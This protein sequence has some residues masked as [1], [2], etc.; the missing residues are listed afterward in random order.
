MLL[1]P[2]TVPLTKIV[3][4]FEP[5]TT[6][7]FTYVPLFER[8]TLPSIQIVPLMESCWV[9]LFQAR[10]PTGL[11]PLSL[12]VQLKLAPLGMRLTVG[13]LPFAMP[14]LS[15]VNEPDE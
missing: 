6:L 7:S 1:A 10:C 8:L 2:L 14:S 11:P 3:P 13:A 9:A 12:T 4:P 5:G 15:K